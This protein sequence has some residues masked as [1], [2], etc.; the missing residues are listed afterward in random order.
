M[1]FCV[2]T[3]IPIFQNL[4]C[5]YLCAQAMSSISLFFFIFSILFS[6]FALATVRNAPT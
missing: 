5:N 1:D 6:N 3:H 4:H 2:K